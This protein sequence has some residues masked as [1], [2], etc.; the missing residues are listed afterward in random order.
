MIGFNIRSSVFNLR[1]HGA[2]DAGMRQ[3]MKCKLMLGPEQGLLSYALE[4]HYED[5]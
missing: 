4:A 3:P 2:N 5:V 1:H